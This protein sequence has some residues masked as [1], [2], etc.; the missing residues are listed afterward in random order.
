M[1]EVESKVSGLEDDLD[2][3]D[4][5][6][7]KLQSLVENTDNSSNKCNICLRGLKE[8]VEGG[9][10]LEYLVDLFTGHLGSD[11]DISIQIANAYQIGSIRKAQR[12]PHEIIVKFPSWVIKTKVQEIFRNEPL[13]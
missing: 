11:L 3:L 10:L 9:N 13:P 7:E 12:R 5:E 2:Q 1:T 6:V 8:R 4:I